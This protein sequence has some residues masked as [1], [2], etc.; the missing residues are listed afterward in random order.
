MREICRELRRHKVAAWSR[1]GQ[2]LVV[3]VAQKQPITER[4]SILSCR[5]LQ[6]REVAATNHVEM[7]NWQASAEGQ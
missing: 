6:C 4:C 2:N 7:K 3:A 5:H 1:E